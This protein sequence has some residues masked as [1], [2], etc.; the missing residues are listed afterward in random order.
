MLPLLGSMKEK[1]LQVL[2]SDKLAQELW[3]AD[4]IQLNR[5]QKEAI[6]K[7]VTNCFQ[8]IQGPPGM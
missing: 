8:L 3:T 1:A 5:R 6:E 7:A 4:R 2:S